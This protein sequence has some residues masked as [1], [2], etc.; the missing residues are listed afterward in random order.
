M[1]DRIGQQFG[2]FRLVRL[3]GR[4]GFAEVYLG[5]HIH[6]ESHQVAIKVLAAELN[7]REIDL[8]RNEASNMLSLHHPNIVRVTDFG[9]IDDRTPYIVIVYAPNGTFRD[10]HPHGTPLPLST[11][12][13][14]IL[15]LA[16]A[17]HYAHAQKKLIHRDIKPENIL[18]GPNQEVLLS[19][20]GLATTAHRTSTQNPQD[21]A[22]TA[23]YMAPEQFKGKPRPASDQY[24]LGI[25]VYEWLTGQPPFTEGEA[26][27]LAYQHVY[28]LPPPLRN[29]L[30]SIS[31][32][33]EQA[34]LKAIEKDPAARFATIQMF[35]QALEAAYKS[36]QVS[37][38]SSHSYPP[39]PS[40]S[41]PI[42]SRPAS[43]PPSAQPGQAPPPPWASSGYTPIARASSVYPASQAPYLPPLLPSSGYQSQIPYPTPQS[44]QSPLPNSPQQLYPTPQIYQPQPAYIPT[45]TNQAKPNNL[46]LIHGR[47]LKR[48]ILVV[49]GF[50]VCLLLLTIPALLSKQPTTAAII[51]GSI[52]LI[53]IV[54][55]L[56]LGGA[57]FGK[58]R[59]MLAS[60]IYM[61]LTVAVGTVVNPTVSTINTSALG[62]IGL[63]IATFIIGILYERRST[64]GCLGSIGIMLLGSEILAISLMLPS[65]LAVPSLSSLSTT[66]FSVFFFVF[67]VASIFAFFTSIFERLIQ[68]IVDTRKRK[69]RINGV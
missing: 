37:S 43:L 44:Y 2:N 49:A 24:S 38:H 28:E 23:I 8:F 39:S 25:M 12:I 53:I 20:F 32:A 15:P 63:P 41:S 1:S 13:S 35:A 7:D 60:L 34:V 65:S 69:E 6:I 29:T 68:V 27:Q 18:I 33:V 48:D 40:T 67:I 56:L 52:V 45:T 14:Y 16:D 51:F 58:W 26:I 42:N 5:Q 62:F 66:L 4:G 54:P 21:R 31:P 30:P 9:I 19:D 17:L 3:L 22:G 50:V 64:R 61:S 46:P 36:G 47:A 55:A 11:I 59:G 10:H 57:V